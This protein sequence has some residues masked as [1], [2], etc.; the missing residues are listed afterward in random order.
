VQIQAFAEAPLGTF[1][2]TPVAIL[3]P[4]NVGHQLSITARPA[5]NRRRPR[6]TRSSHV[7]L[8][9]F[10]YC[11]AFPTKLVAQPQRQLFRKPLERSILMQAG[12]ADNTEGDQVLFGII[13]GLTAEFLVV[14]LKI[15][16]GAAGLAS[17]AIA[18]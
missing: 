17:P 12:M 18:L 11:V 3:S 16:H 1:F 14:N 13:A 7:V 2:G 8:E 9:E 4:E 6:N 10:G 5:G 15:R